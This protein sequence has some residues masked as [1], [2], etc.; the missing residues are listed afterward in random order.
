VPATTVDAV[1]LRLAG[2][3][4][5]SD[6]VTGTADPTK[7]KPFWTQTI[8][9]ATGKAEAWLRTTLLGM[10]FRA[11]KIAVWPLFLYYHEDL[12]VFFASEDRR[13]EFSESQAS[14]L[15]G[16][17]CRDEVKALTTLGGAD[18][19]SLV[20]VGDLERDDDLFRRPSVNGNGSL[21]PDVF[22]CNRVAVGWDIR[23]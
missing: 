5:Y 14:G 6:P 3:L 13:A 4:G 1:K 9:R 21:P 16:L 23:R 11:E 18:D 19:D 22:N 20:A 15:D 8:V 2:M 12:A 10:G 17:D 7:L